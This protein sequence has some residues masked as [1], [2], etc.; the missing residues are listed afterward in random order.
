MVASEGSELHF[1]GPDIEGDGSG[2]ALVEKGD[3]E[4]VAGFAKGGADLLFDGELGVGGDDRA[5]LHGVE[6]FGKHG[7]VVGVLIADD[8][9]AFQSFGREGG[10]EM[11]FGVEPGVVAPKNTVF[12]NVEAGDEGVV[13]GSGTSPVVW[14][15]EDFDVGG[16]GGIGGDEEGFRRGDLLPVTDGVGVR[17]FERGADLTQAVVSLQGGGAALVGTVGV[18]DEKVVD[19]VDA[20]MVK[21][22]LEDERELTDGPGVEKPV[23]VA[24]AKMI[25]GIAPGDAQHGELGGG[26]RK[27][28][29]RRDVDMTARDEGEEVGHPENGGGG[30]LTD[31]GEGWLDEGEDRSGE[32]EA[33]DGER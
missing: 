7:V 13:V 20:L 9:V 19:T 25:G 1:F 14:R 18:A 12:A 8:Q 30:L 4:S 21:E 32:D 28:V 24:D 22:R 17:T 31:P 27:E 10:E 23:G 5:R 3:V 15:E 11:F 26:T 29:E 2:L 6:E 33:A 16:E